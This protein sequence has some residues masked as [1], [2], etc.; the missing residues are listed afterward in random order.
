MLRK[1]VIEALPCLNYDY[2]SLD[3]GE[4]IKVKVLREIARHKETS[5]DFAT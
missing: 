2:D 3:K 5:V 1:Q 4:I